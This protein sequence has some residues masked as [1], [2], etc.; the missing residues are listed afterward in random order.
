MAKDDYYVIAYQILAYLY[1]RLKKGEDVDP[2]FLQHDSRLFR[3]NQRYWAYIMYHLAQEGLIEG[4]HFIPI[5]GLDIPLA[6]DLES[7]RITPAGIAYL[8]DNSFIEK[9]KRFLKDVNEI[10]PL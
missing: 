7:C 1:Q 3:I 2:A 10:I 6:C 8:C 4:V 9:A 5:D